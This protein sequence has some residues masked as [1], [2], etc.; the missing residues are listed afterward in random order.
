MNLLLTLLPSEARRLKLHFVISGLIVALLIAWL[1]LDF[2]SIS[3]DI[4]F[5]SQGNIDNGFQSFFSIDSI[6]PTLGIVLPSML[7][8]SAICLVGLL[9]PFRSQ[10]EWETGQFQLLK[11]CSWSQYPIQIVR[12]CIYLVVCLTLTLTIITTMALALKSS[13]NSPA[14]FSHDLILIAFF[15][16]AAFLPL[17]ISI[18]LVIDSIRTAYYLRGIPTIITIIQ[19]TGWMA[20]MNFS[21]KAINSTSFTLLP[22]IPL[23]S[24]KQFP[25]GSFKGMTQLHIEPLILSFIIA[26][27]FVVLSG[28]VL[29]EAEA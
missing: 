6:I 25:Q 10:K 28:R 2:D 7:A 12:F 15:M 26:L 16:I 27:S 21:Q 8:L 17:G 14:Q 1:G 3:G 29:E 9:M 22:S 20:M 13:P 11:M 19:L 18:G 23:E 24:V 4:S 5:H